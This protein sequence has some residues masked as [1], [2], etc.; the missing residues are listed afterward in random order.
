M[1]MHIRRHSNTQ[2]IIKEVP[3]ERVVEKPVE[4]KK[5]E[6]RDVV[7]EVE[8]VKEVPKTPRETAGS[9]PDN[10]S[11]LVADL[12]ALHALY[13]WMDVWMHACVHAC[14][15]PYL[16]VYVSIYMYICSSMSRYT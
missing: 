2:V 6:F 7:K 15:Y 12:L 9:N 14:M 16:S 11:K 4:V 13:G 8:V 10:N 5:I 3:T 1:H